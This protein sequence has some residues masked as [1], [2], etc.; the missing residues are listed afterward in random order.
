MQDIAKRTCMQLNNALAQM[1][2]ER[3]LYFV[4]LTEV[5]AGD[6]E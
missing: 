2:Y 6:D 3:G 4:D 1:A 5:L